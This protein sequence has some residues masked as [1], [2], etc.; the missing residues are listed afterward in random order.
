MRRTNQREGVRR[1]GKGVRRGK[2]AAGD[3]KRVG[4]RE[5]FNQVTSGD[6]GSKRVGGREGFNQVTSGDAKRRG[7]VGLDFHC[8]L[9][10]IRGG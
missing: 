6:A 2:N 10:S 8:S 1:K 7:R 3:S 5:G 9:V 4:G